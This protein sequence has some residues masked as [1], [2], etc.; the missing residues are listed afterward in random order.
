M[1]HRQLDFFLRKGERAGARRQTA[2]S[3]KRQK[4]I[5]CLRKEKVET[6]SNSSNNQ[7]SIAE[8]SWR[9]P[10]CYW[11]NQISVDE[12]H[13]PTTKQPHQRPQNQICEDKGG[14]RY[15]QCESYEENDND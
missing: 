11:R 1:E 2:K 4:I 8:P 14:E 9:C 10:R 5:S 6:S 13:L 15:K 3:I 12:E 7:T